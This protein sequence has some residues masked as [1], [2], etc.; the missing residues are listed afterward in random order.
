MDLGEIGWG[1]MDRIYLVQ[2]R[3]RCKG[4]C[5][6]GMKLWASENAGKYFSS[7]TTGSFSR[8]VQLHGIS[9]QFI[10]ILF[11]HLLLRISSHITT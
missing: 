2:Y 6:L 5:K 10:S 8:R 4:S 3:D 7:C 9:F 1:D 11:F